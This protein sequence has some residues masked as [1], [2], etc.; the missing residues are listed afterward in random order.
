MLDEE[1]QEEVHHSFCCHGNQ[2][3]ANQ[4]PPERIWR[5]LLTWDGG[6]QKVTGIRPAG[7]PHEDLVTT[8]PRQ[9]RGYTKREA[10]G[11]SRSHSGSSSWSREE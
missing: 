2:V 11:K 1:G 5:V 9:T 3:L 6:H 10:R 8:Q 7:L 4:V